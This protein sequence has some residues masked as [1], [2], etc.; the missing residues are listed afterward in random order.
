MIRV[1]VADDHALVRAGLK[2]ILGKTG[3]ISVVGEACNGQEVMVEARR[4]P[5]DVVLLDIGM[6]GRSGLDVLKQLRAEHPGLSVLILT[7]YPEEQ[8]AVR[9]LRAGAAG[10]LTKDSGPEELVNAVRKVASGGRYVTMRAAESLAFEVQGRLR[11]SPHEALSDRE[12]QVL[13]MIARGKTVNEIAAELTLSAKTVST[14]RSRV[15]AKLNLR[16]NSEIAY[17][18][19]KEGL[20]D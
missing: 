12:L 7:M 8:Y 14:Y 18:A 17:Y 13:C 5:C 20:V 4:T 19:V 6:P 2:H 16:N 9:A 10:Y 11:Q 3:E 15:L 1:L